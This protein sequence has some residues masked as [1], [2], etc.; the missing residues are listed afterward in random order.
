MAQGGLLVL[1]HLPPLN[2]VFVRPRAVPF[3]REF[4]EQHAQNTDRSAKSLISFRLSPYIRQHILIRSFFLPESRS[5]SAFLMLT[6]HHSGNRTHSEYMKS[7]M[8]TTVGGK[9]NKQ[10]YREAAN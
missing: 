2:T 10:T 7:D 4:I 9:S 6:E 3:V 1:S 8:T 5:L